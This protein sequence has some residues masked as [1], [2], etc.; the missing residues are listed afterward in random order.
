MQ[1]HDEGDVGI[2]DGLLHF[3]LL[4]GVSS[5]VVRVRADDA[6]LIGRSDELGRPVANEAEQRARRARPAA[7]SAPRTGFGRL[8]I[9]V[10]PVNVVSTLPDSCTKRSAAARSSSCPPSPAKIPT[11]ALEAREFAASLRYH[12]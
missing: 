3:C 1:V 6:E 10:F 2:V 5:G 12:A 9:K 11:S 4:G 7:T 8:Q